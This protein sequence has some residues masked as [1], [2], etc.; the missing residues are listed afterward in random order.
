MKFHP[1]VSKLPKFTQV[2]NDLWFLQTLKRINCSMYFLQFKVRSEGK[3]SL[4]IP[5]NPPPPRQHPFPA[6]L[7]QAGLPTEALA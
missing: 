3:K 5:P 2:L 7:P 1:E 6:C 4:S